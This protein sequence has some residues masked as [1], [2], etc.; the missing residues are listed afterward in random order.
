MSDKKYR[1]DLSL[2]EIELISEFINFKIRVEF[3]WNPEVYEETMKLSKYLNRKLG[4][5]KCQ[6][7]LDEVKK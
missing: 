5:Y 4:Y 7:K 2:D 6:E 3:A 1:L